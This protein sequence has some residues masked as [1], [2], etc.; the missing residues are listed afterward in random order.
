MNRSRYPWEQDLIEA[1]LVAERDKHQD[2]IAFA[3]EA[4]RSRIAE[5]AELKRETQPHGHTKLFLKSS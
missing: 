3:E 2:K 5:L 1:L 4:I